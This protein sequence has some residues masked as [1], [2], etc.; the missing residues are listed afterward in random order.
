[1]NFTQI[2]GVGVLMVL[3]VLS[4]LGLDPSRFATSKHFVSWLGLCPESRITGGKC[5]SSK[6]RQVANRVATALR[7]AAQTLVRS[8]SLI[9]PWV[10]F[11]VACKPV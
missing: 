8:H 5:K 3:A 2:D 7:M 11:T 10:P 1:M 6:T 4:E 9:Q